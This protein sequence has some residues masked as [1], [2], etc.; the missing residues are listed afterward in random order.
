MPIITNFEDQ[1]IRLMKGHQYGWFTT[2]VNLGG[3]TGVSG[4]TGGPIGGFTGQLRQ[5][6]VTFDLSENEI[7]TIPISG[8]SLVNN[9]DR[10]RYRIAAVE[11]GGGGT[12]DTLVVQWDDA[13]I[14]SGVIYLNFEGGVEVVDDGG[15]KVTV[16]VSGAGGTHDAVAIRGVSVVDWEPTVSG[17]VLIYD[18]NVWAP[19]TVGGGAI[20]FLDLTD[21]PSD[22]TGYGGYSAVVN[23]AEDGLEFIDVS[24][25]AGAGYT[26]AY[27]DVTSQVPDGSDDFTLAATPASGSLVVHYNGITQQ[28]DNY[29]IITGGFHTL[30]SPVSGEELTAEYYTNVPQGNILG[31]TL[32][33][34]DT[35][36]TETT[37]VAILNFEGMSVTDEGSG[38]VT[39]SGG[40][41]G[42]GASEPGHLVSGTTATIV[43]GTTP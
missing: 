6:K 36:V 31:L 42:G 32:E 14:A 37:N 16:T 22:Y 28:P 12:G 4:G 5:D 15:S 34:Q 21:T 13:Q 3:V 19:G 26:F 2:G 40:T 8:E 18:G 20:T 17:E 27:E 38:K 30:F 29:N 33:V 11:D 35:D 10:I 41:G 23:I 9:L 24:G 25:G 7:W 39:V 43:A 1:I